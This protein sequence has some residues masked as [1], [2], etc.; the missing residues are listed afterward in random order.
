MELQHYLAVI[1]RRKWVILIVLAVVMVVT[2]IGQ[3]RLTPVY[4]ANTRI[5][6]AVSLGLTQNSQLY[7]YN[8]QLM[9]TFVALATS[10]PVLA[11]LLDRL[12]IQNLPTIEVAVVPNTELIRITTSSSDPELAALTSN[13]LAQI[14]IEQNTELFAGGA[15]PSSEILSEQVEEA[16]RELNKVR[17]EY[18][19]LVLQ[20]P[21]PPG[22]TPVAPV[23]PPAAP[24]ELT[25]TNL[26]LQEKQRTYETLLREYEEALYREALAESMITVVEEALVPRTPSEPRVTLNYMIAS[27]AGLL[28]GVILAFVFENVDPRLYTAPEIEAAAQIPVL[29]RLPKAWRKY[30]HIFKNTASRYAESVRLL[31]ARIHLA[32]HRTKQN[33][34]VFAGAEPGQGTSTAVANLGFALDEQ[35]KN[36][37]I[38]DCN[39][40]NPS[41]HTL[42]GL[43]N[44]NGLVDVLS[45]SVELKEVLQK[46][47]SG[48]LSLLS[49][50]SKAGQSYQPL[51][52]NQAGELIKGLRQKFDYVLLDSPSLSMADIV[53][54]APHADEII[55]V[56]R[57]S[58][59]KRQALHSAGEFLSRFKDKNLGLIVNES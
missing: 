43:A 1:W 42:F 41:L 57:C 37:V 2:A 50:G 32:D 33:V 5:R 58:R 7:T 31:A 51:N 16:R 28:A 35:G 47:G 4:T 53:S 59:V 49:F 24:D 26:L 15:L 10:R 8:S 25:V 48:N 30:L 40:R 14:L 17:E 29:G 11:E 21:I 12:Q 23:L 13:T 46:S 52:P 3:R 22:T 39:G 36:V 56:A 9:N 38:V 55:L 54:V 34:I 44:E 45:G 18:E 6:V 19:R 27:L 20:T